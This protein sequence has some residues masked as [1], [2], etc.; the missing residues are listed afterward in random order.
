MISKFPL[1]FSYK[2]ISYCLPYHCRSLLKGLAG[3]RY[4]V[5]SEWGGER[6]QKRGDQ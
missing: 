1:R 4:T 6:V 5:L 2:W 3:V